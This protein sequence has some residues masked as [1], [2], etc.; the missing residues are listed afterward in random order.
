MYLSKLR[1]LLADGTGDQVLVTDASGYVLRVAPEQVDAN[2]FEALL[3]QGRQELA[4]G[5]PEAAAATLRSGLALWRGPALADFADDGFARSE[6]ARLEELRLAALEE[7]IEADLLLGRHSSLVPEL[8]TLAAQHPYRERLHGQL[9]LALYRSGRQ[10]EALATYR[11]VRRTLVDE[12]GIEPGAPLQELER[13]ILT[14]DASLE[15]PAKQRRPLDRRRA[16][17]GLVDR[18]PRVAVMLAGLV[19]V[20]ALAAGVLLLAARDTST[21]SATPLVLAG[22]SV[23]VV[24]PTTSSVVDEIPIGPIPG[25][26]AVGNGS[27][28]VGSRHERTLM[29]IDPRSRRIVRTIGLS[30]E[31]RGL[32]FAANSIWIP[33]DAGI[34][35][36]RVDTSVNDVVE[37]I[38]IRSGT[39]ACCGPGLAVGGGAVW[40]S[41]LGSVSRIDTATNEVVPVRDDD[42]V[43]IAYGHGA[44]WALT[45]A[46]RIDRIDPNTHKVVDTISRA[47]VGITDH[48]GVLAVG[49]GAVWTGSS[50]TATLWS[51]D[52]AT[53]RFAGSVQLGHMPV[54]VAFGEGA[55]WVVTNDAILLRVDPRSKRVVQTTRLGAYS[56][57]VRPNIAVGEGGVWLSVTI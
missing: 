5:H 44:L 47:A 33:N 8:E 11:Q 31:P 37:T 10:A 21:S 20:L 1:R 35:V 42:V 9:M 39:E 54:G 24:D 40:V 50:G 56:A 53:G 48:T 32:A 38:R 26:I 34:A 23:G 17:L 4:A 43:T 46:N 16:G 14:H 52:P 3:E 55:M 22:D 25:G 49:E 2:R 30:V 12:L 13:A 15:P 27:V 57:P 7:R 41:N 28:W 51:I 19:L 29:R 6:V 45:T 36:L 18:I